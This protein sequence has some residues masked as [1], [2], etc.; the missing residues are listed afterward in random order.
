M[1]TNMTR[2]TLRRIAAV[3]RLALL[4]AWSREL[5][6]PHGRLSIWRKWVI[7]AGKAD[8][9][10][11]GL[12]LSD[13]LNLKNLFNYNNHYAALIRG[14]IQE[15]RGR[16]PLNGCQRV[17]ASEWMPAIWWHWVPSFSEIHSMES[18]QWNSLEASARI[19]ENLR[20][21]SVAVCHTLYQNEWR[22]LFG[23]FQLPS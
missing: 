15:Q 21:I 7:R 8:A 18:A 16:I 1:P 3:W 12:K 17:D 10:D 2:I 19:L 5:Y 22:S 9:P 23:A 11:V 6:G 13:L 14:R 20:P 4:A